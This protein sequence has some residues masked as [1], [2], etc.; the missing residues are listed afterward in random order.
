MKRTLLLAAAAASLGVS[1]SAAD[2]NPKDDITSAA[3]EL[4][5]KAN[6]SWH[7][8]V[9]VPEDSRF[10]PG[11]TDGKTEKEGFTCLTLRFGDNTTQAVLKGEKAA[12]TTADSD[13]Q[14]LSE[15]DGAE[16]PTRFLG[17]MLRNFKSPAAQV[18][19][20]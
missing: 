2:S 10:R 11:P 19:Q 16:G 4:A 15:L 12:A 13:W 17:M 6:Y 8:T 20:L 14:S 5:D 3:K 18:T 1:L 9:K 7:T